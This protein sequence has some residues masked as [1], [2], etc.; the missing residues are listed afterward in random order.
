[1]PAAQAVGE[2]ART[3]SRALAPSRA[4]RAG[5][6]CRR[7]R[8]A[9][10]ARCVAGRHDEA[11]ALVL[12][13]AACGGADGVGG[14]HG[15]SLVEG[16][17]DDEAPRLQEVA[18][19]DRRH[20]HNV[21]AGVEVAQRSGGWGP[22][23]CAAPA[24]TA[25]AR[26]GPSPTRTS[27]VDGADRPARGQARRSTH[28]PLFPRQSTGKQSL[29]RSQTLGLRGCSPERV[30][31]ALRRLHDGAGRALGAHVGRDVRPVGRDRVGVAVERAQRQV[32]ERVRGGARMRPDRRPEHER[33]ARAARAQPRR[34]QRHT[35]REPGDDR[36]IAPG[37][38]EPQHAALAR[39]QHGERRPR[40][41]GSLAGV[42]PGAEPAPGGVR[43]RAAAVADRAADQ[44]EDGVLA[45]VQ[46]AEGADAER[47]RVVGHEQHGPRVRAH[48]S[49]SS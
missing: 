37:R 15:D 48:R 16:F 32:G 34:G 2:C 24:A 6:S 5:S 47:R 12:D 42:R 22:S 40:G 3:A 25:R 28:D 11:G 19:G 30:V 10:S 33:H 43:R 23:R 9:A 29:E 18:R 35:A 14:D 39:A 38:R 8:A 36:A 45:L 49:A 20:H 4:R 31:D 41:P 46:L 1:M 17:V 27:A 26:I 21:A 13:E 44:R 7:R